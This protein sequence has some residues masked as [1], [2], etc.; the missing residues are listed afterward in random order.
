MNDSSNIDELASSATA[1]EL[2]KAQKWTQAKFGGVAET[3]PDEG[4]LTVNLTAGR[5]QRSEVTTTG[6]GLYAIASR[7]LRIADRDYGRGLHFPSEGEVVVHLP[8]PAKTFEAT[9]GVDSNRVTG[10]YSNAGR[11]TV[12]AKV[13]VNG[14]EVFRSDVLH[15]G[16]EGIPVTIQLNGAT[17]FVLGLIDAGRGTIQRVNFNQVDWA[18]ARVNL[19]DGETVWL[20]DLPTAPLRAS[21]STDAP[22]SFRYA[23]QP[24]GDF[25]DGWKLERDKRALDEDRTELTTTYTDPSTGLQVRCVA[26]MYSAFPVVEWTLYFKNTG[27]RPTPIIEDIQ[28]IDTQLERGGDGEFRLHHGDGSPH[29][30][31]APQTPTQYAPRETELTPRTEKHL[32]AM[33]G[34]PAG[35]DLPYFNVECNGEG[36][37]I[38]IGWLG[39]WAAQFIRDNAYGLRIRAGQELTH[40]KL[41]PGE[42][43]RTPLI[44]MLFW[45]GDWI[46]SQNLWRRWMIRHN[47]PRPGGKLPP[48]QLEASGS[49]QYIEMSLATEENQVEFV[50]RYFEEKIGIDYWWMDAGWHIFR[51]YWLSLGTWTPDPERFPRGLRPV[52]DHVRSKGAKV[53]LWFVPERTDPGEWLYENHP[54]WLLGINGGRKL[55]NFGDPDAWEWALNHFDTLIVEQG[56]DLFRMDGDSTLPY[57]RANDTEDRQGIT[58]IRHVEGVLAFWDELRRRHPDMLMDICAGGGARNALEALRRAVPLWRSDYAYETTGMQNLTRAMSLWIPFFGTGTNAFESYTFR[59]QMAPALCCIWDLRRRDV[60]YT[61]QRRMVAEWRQVAGNY[62]GDYYPLTTYRTED[63]VWAAWQFDRPESGQGMVQAF[64]RQDSDITQMCF[65]LRGLDAS[66]HYTVTNMDIDGTTKI[67]GKDLTENGLSITIEE[68]PGAALIVYKRL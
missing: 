14:N 4:Y 55:L 62:Y 51:E 43:V 33:E 68:Q 46:R 48:P 35:G 39:Q 58:E 7:P 60:D 8:K 26:E 6:Y 67:S 23:G 36:A 59:S 28:A 25:L 53:I 12:I 52:S 38:A 32:L 15:E 27:E 66:A 57:W 18:E 29:S 24:S 10:F 37:I 2:D 61:F 21:Y 54:E 47:L 9:L 40:F 31:L 49:A 20:D 3:K 63:D 1:D 45:E 19:D 65:K 41:L 5:V 42:E 30:G 17:E 13:D 50:D 22:F 16:I 34:L 56:V 11:G 44:A 64:R